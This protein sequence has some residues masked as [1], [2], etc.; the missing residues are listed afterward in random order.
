MRNKNIEDI[1]IVKNMLCFRKISFV[2]DIKKDIKINKDGL[3]VKVII[4]LRN[5]LS[6]LCAEGG[7]E[8]KDRY[9]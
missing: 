8:T 4:L 7:M 5:S 1:G 3:L 2:K 6:F 9:A